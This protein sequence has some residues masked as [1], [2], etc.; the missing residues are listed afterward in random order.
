MHSEKQKHSMIYLNF[1]ENAE[2]VFIACGENKKWFL[3]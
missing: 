1:N 2:W 3:L